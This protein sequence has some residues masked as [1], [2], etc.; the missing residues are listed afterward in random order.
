VDTFDTLVGI[1][2]GASKP[3]KPSGERNVKMDNLYTYETTINSQGGYWNHIYYKFNWGDEDETGWIESPE[4]SH[5]WLQQG[6]FQ[7]K[8]KA[9]LTHEPIKDPEDAEEFKE[10][11]W[12]DPLIIT[13]TKTRDR[14]SFTHPLIQFLQNFLSN[15]QNAFPLLRLLLKL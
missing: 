5:I 12:S 10:S 7:V 11:D 15:Y 2:F 1:E 14:Q 9:M 6:I 3:T 4:A 13:V 8:V